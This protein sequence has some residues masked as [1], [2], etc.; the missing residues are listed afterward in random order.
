MGTTFRQY[1]NWRR[2]FLVATALSRG[3]DLTQAAYSAGFAS[4]AHL[5]TSFLKM[6]G[7]SPSFLLKTKARITV[8]AQRRL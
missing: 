8:M 7:L 2:M 1:R 5:S 4:S 3:E 6:F